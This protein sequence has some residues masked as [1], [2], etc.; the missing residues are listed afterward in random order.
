MREANW[1]DDWHIGA[2]NARASFARLVDVPP[3]SVSLIPAASVGV[4]TIAASREAASRAPKTSS[5]RC[6]TRCSW[7]SATVKAHGR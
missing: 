2:E 4:G 6:S 7:L 5:R 3:T 1:I